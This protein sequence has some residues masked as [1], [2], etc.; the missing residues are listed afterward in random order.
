MKSLVAVDPGGKEDADLHVF[1]GAVF[2]FS[3]A[4]FALVYRFEHRV[5]ETRCGRTE[6]DLA[7]DEF[8]RLYFLNAGAHLN[9]AS[10]ETVVVVS[11][12]G[13][14]ALGKIGEEFEGLFPEDGDARVDEFVKI[15]WE[16]FAGKADRNALGPVGE[17][18][19]KLRRQSNRLLVSPVVARGPGCGL[20][21]KK[22]FVGEL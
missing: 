2:N 17:D 20:G 16:D 10:A 14:T 4:H 8:L 19:R 21:I 13:D 9:A 6:G 5:D 7:D 18:E 22:D 1:S 11:D 12:I 15:V 3:D